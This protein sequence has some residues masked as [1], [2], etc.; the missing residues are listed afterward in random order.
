MFGDPHMTNTTQTLADF[1][2]VGS[3]GCGKTA[4]MQALLGN[5][6][7]VLKTQAAVFHDNQVIDTPGEFIG[8]RNYYGALLATIVDV[9]TIV[10]LQ[11]ANSVI[12]SLPAGLLHVYPDKRVMGVI[13]KTDLPD[14]EV[15]AA[16]KV[17]SDNGIAEPHFATS[18]ATGSGVAELRAYLIGLQGKTVDANA[19]QQQ[20]VHQS[21]AAPCHSP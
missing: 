7:E 17:L 14:A 19:R 15:A 5:E 20:T 6:G 1:V 18:A 8:R 10:Y 11:P 21:H 16:S 3:V 12:F 2:L 9:S 13:S 4:L